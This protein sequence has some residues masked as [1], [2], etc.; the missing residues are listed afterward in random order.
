MAKTNP[1]G[2]RFDSE[3]LE[4]LKTSSIADS[5]QKALNVYERSFLELTELK[6]GLNNKPENKEKIMSVRKATDGSNPVTVQ[7][8]LE[9]F[10][11]HPLWKEDDPG[12]NSLSFMMKY[13]VMNYKE[14]EEYKN[15][16]NDTAR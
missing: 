1:I 8:N 2:V 3:L 6:I 14:L 10:T 15:K 11:K 4:K 5:P 9:S 12:E 13:G 16:K 7:L